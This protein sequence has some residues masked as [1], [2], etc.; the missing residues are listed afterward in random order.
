[1]DWSD[2]PHLSQ[3]HREL[4]EHMAQG[5]GEQALVNLLHCPPEQHVSQLEQFE[6]FVLGQ[7]RNASEVNS[8]AT[9][10]S[11]TKTQ[12]ELRLEQA[13]NE[14]LNRTVET[15]SA[16]PAQPRPIRMDPP[17]FDGATP[18]T[19]VHWLLAVEQ[20]SEWA[21]SALMANADEFSSWKIFKS[22]IRAMY[23][24]PNNEV[25]LMARF[26][27]ARQAKRSLQEFVQEMRS[28][29]A[30]INGEPIPER[31]KVATFMYGLR[32]GPSRQA[33]FRKVPATMEEAIDIALVKEQSYNSASATAYYRPSSEKS[34]ATPMELGNAD[35]IC[36]KCG[37]QGHMMARCY[38]K[39]AA[40][41]KASSKRSPNP[42]GGATN[43]RARRTGSAPAQ[44][45]SGN[46]GAQ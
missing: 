6:A 9:A 19:I 15:L 3:H 28:L 12:D 13:R 40:G 16:R 27:G 17:K 41:A 18:H 45:G 31:I 29:S 46:A 4:A 42:K 11:I 43:Q 38:A 5:L 14:A 26:F 32:H 33:L 35:V 22:K 10:E 24:P 2:F 37:K 34:D 21:Y 7:R 25:L 30:S 39:V 8:Q 20:S 44:D 23:Q 36:Y 1:M